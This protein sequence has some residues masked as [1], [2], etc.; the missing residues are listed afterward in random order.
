M[1]PTPL[2]V[3]GLSVAGGMEAEIWIGLRDGVARYAKGLVET[4]DVRPRLDLPVT[5]L[6][7]LSGSELW[8]A[9]DGV[10]SHLAIAGG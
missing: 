3:T 1:A 9:G 7:Y 5:A 8:V 10:V 4:L 6:L 2:P